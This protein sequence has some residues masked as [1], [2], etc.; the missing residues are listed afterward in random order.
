MIVIFMV[1]GSFIIFDDVF[2]PSKEMCESQANVILKTAES[3]KCN[4]CKH[5]IY[6]DRFEMG[7]LTSEAS[8]ELNKKIPKDNACKYY[9]FSESHRDSVETAV[10]KIKSQYLNE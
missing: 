7:Y 2:N 9:I 5:Y 1:H 3:N 4:Y 10:N 6:N 8:C